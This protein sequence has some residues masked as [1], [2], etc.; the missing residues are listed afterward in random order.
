MAWSNR[1]MGALEQELVE[2]EEVGLTGRILR[3][4]QVHEEL[5]SAFEHTDD[6]AK[7][8]EAYE[9]AVPLCIGLTG[10]LDALIRVH[11]VKKNYDGVISATTRYLERR[12]RAGGA[13]GTRAWAHLQKKNYQESFNDYQRSVEL[14]HN[15]AYYGLAWHY[16][17]GFVVP[18]DYRRAIDLYMT[19]ADRG[20]EGARARALK[21]GKEAGIP[22][23]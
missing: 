21:V 3:G 15:E 1:S 12:P 10:A 18:K 14:G 7:A 4:P 8:V 22:V 13:Y 16:E 6:T 11:R 9:R 5:G 2:F 17:W 20:V 23:R 19:A